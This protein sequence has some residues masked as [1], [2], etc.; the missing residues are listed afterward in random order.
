M[1]RITIFSFLE[2]SL[3]F[4]FSYLGCAFL[5]LTQSGNLKKGEITVF[6]RSHYEDVLIVKVH[7]WIDAAE[8]QRRFAQIN[9]FEKMLNKKDTVTVKDSTP[10][11]NSGDKTKESVKGL[12]D[13]LL[14]KKPK[15]TANKQ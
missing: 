4:K 13:N 10:V 14:K 9:A 5:L 7:D 11:K 2:K 6:N 8:C 12:F 3:K 1:S 15:D